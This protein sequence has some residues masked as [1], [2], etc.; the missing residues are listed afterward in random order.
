MLTTLYLLAAAHADSAFPAETGLIDAVGR[1][2]AH[3]ALR[4]LE[5]QG[6]VTTA[7]GGPENI[8]N[9]VLTPRGLAEARRILSG[10]EMGEDGA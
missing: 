3:K 6:M 7:S 8:T 4:K 5:A 10:M 9:W 1:V 2:S